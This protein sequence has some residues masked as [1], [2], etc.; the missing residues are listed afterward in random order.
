MSS[1]GK[2]VTFNESLNG[3][4]CQNVTPGIRGSNFFCL[5]FSNS[6]AYGTNNIS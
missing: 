6:E 5:L 4:K 2:S 3:Y 1:N